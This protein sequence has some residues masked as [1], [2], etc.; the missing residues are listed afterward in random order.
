[1]IICFNVVINTSDIILVAAARCTLAV[2][3]E[4]LTTDY[5]FN[6][7]EIWCPSASLLITL[8]QRLLARAQEL[9]ARLPSCSR[10][11]DVF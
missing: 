2:G 5:R 8:C 7:F 4:L 11:R 1:M 10:I 6:F 3:G 9:P